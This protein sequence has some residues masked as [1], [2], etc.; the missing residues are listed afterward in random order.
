MPQAPYALVRASLNGGAVQTGG[1]VATGGETCQLSADPAGLAGATQVL[2]E[3]LDRPAGFTLPAGWSLATDGYTYRYLGASP[4]VFTLLSNANWGKYI[5][6]LTLNGGGPALT[7]RETAAQLERIAALTDNATAISVPSF[8]GLRDL[9]YYEKT[10]FSFR[11]WVADMKANLRLIQTLITSAGGG[12][13]TN[14]HSAL[15]NLLVDSHTQYL[16]ASGARALSG[17]LNLGGNKI[18]NLGTPTLATDAATKGYV[19][20]AGG[21]SPAGSQIEGYTIKSFGGIPTWAPSSAYSITSFALVTPVLEVGAAS[22]NP[23]FSAAHSGTPTSLTLTNGD[24]AE[25]K[26][27]HATPNSFASSVTRTKS[28]NNASTVYTLTGSDGLSSAN[29]SASQ[30]WRPRVF[31]GTGAAG[32]NTEAFIEALANSEL[33]ASRVKTFTDNASGSLR[34]YFAIPASYGTPTFTVGGFSGGF[35]LVSASITVTNAFGVTQNYALYVSDTPGL[36]S[37]T[38]AVT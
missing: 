14:N 22:V 9:A 23:A 5:I 6:R 36:G 17:I 25:S 26:D 27:V 24:D 2:W 1:I 10:Q 4:P 35:S 13:G 16:L 21:F 28:V 33:L 31:W 7:G 8:D 12:S 20:S 32:G 29:R 15:S 18:T 30:F 34:I 3:I 38:V 11:G 37:T 19:D